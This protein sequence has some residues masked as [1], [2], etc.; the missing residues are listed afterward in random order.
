MHSSDLLEVHPLGS[1]PFVM[2]TKISILI[3]AVNDVV[4]RSTYGDDEEDVIDAKMS[5]VEAKLQAFQKNLPPGSLALDPGLYLAHNIYY[6]CVAF[7]FRVRISSDFHS[8][9]E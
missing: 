3:S 4:I 2:W 6:V 5:E 7:S 1:D 9:A 8:I